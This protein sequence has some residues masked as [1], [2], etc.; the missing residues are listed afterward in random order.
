LKAGVYHSQ[1]IDSE[2][3]IRDILEEAGADLSDGPPIA[4][5]VH[6]GIDHDLDVLAS[7]L[8]D[9]WPGLQLIG[10]TADAELSS[11]HGKS[12]DSVVV[13]LL[14][15][16]R[17]RMS[18]GA[19]RGLSNDPAHATRMAVNQAL[20]GVEPSD[21]RLCV[22]LL[23][24]VGVDGAEVLDHLRTAVPEGVPIVGGMAGDQGRFLVSKQV[25]GR[26]EL[27]DSVCVLLFSGPLVLSTA[28]GHGW[29]PV[30]G[31]HR[32]TRAEGHYG[33]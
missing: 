7:A 1:D 28:A 21:V 32:V 16:G 5:M 29:T 26:E 8:L 9:R 20:Q 19:G 13:M 24:G 33:A 14:G 17:V 10:C 11:V 2:D 31:V 4:C 12:D 6:A 23:E 30:G 27:T 22:S 15:S 18:A 25:V 3:A